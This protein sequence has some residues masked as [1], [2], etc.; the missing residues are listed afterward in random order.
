MPRYAVLL[1]GVNVGKGRRVPM[2][3]LK[4]VLEGLGHTGVVTLLNS[5]NAVFTGAAGAPA[6]HAARIA[7]ALKA[8]LD[9]DV[10]VIVKT[11][12]E[13]ARIVAGVP[14][15]LPEAE[16]PR[17]LIAFA[18]DAA[19]LRPLAAVAPLVRPPER[20]HIGADAAYLHCPGGLHGSAAA[21]ALL[22]KAGKAVT[23]R[24][25]ATT[26]KLLALCGAD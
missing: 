12:A 1:R 7:A 18:P 20:W 15:A 6:G 5:G 14:F 11:Q 4:W 25:R 10:P 26:G 3:Q 16:H 24:N 21:E 19:A 9:V 22:G 17:L 23:T 2:A 13:L 8:A